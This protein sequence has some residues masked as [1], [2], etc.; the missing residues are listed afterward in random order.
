MSDFLKQHYIYLIIIL[1]LIIAIVIGIFTKKC[2][3]VCTVN[4]TESGSENN[5]NTY[6]PPNSEGFI[7]STKKWKQTCYIGWSMNY[8]TFENFIDIA[9]NSGITHIIL[10]FIVCA[11]PLEKL[12]Y[13][14]TVTE[15]QNYS[16][17]Q[18]TTLI[19]KMNKYGIT[20][21]VS[22]GGATSFMDGLEKV[23]NSK[24]SNSATLANELVDWMYK[25]KVTGIDLDIEHL[26]REWSDEQNSKIVNY[27]G[28]LSQN[29]KKRGKELGFYIIVS[30]APQTPY[31]NGP[32]N[33]Q[34]YGGQ[35]G[36]TYN[37][38][39]QLYGAYI[40]FYNIQYYNQGNIY[41]DYNSLF[42]KD[43][44]NDGTGFNAAV[45]QLINANSVNAL[46][47]PIPDFKIVIGKP[48]N[49]LEVSNTQGFINLYSN[50]KNDLTM[51]NYVNMTKTS[52]DKDLQ[53][54]YK[55]GGIMIWIYK[56]EDNGTIKI[57][58][59]NNTQ[60][61]NYFTSTKH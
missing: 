6:N 2:S 48:N 30:H 21:M 53:N 34:Y 39:E 41:T 8:D 43:G 17:T 16:D 26:P 38:I 4:T 1:I 32:M 42:I 37:K 46:Y 47:F 49:P 33:R 58:D 50:N 13:F 7:A 20:V 11:P 10:E 59:P 5:S 54:W 15:W 29:I 12:T 57:N 45:L 52:Q 51:N 18:K 24:Y 27:L 40:D 25:N 19:N 9:H 22:F 3:N 36:Y 56:N 61:I 55:Y 31:Y 14:D 23:F 28:S 44:P 60:T 35:W